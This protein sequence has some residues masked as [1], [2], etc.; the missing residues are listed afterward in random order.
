MRALK[1]DGRHARTIRTRAAIVTAVVD[2]LDEGRIEPTAAEI[3]DRAGVA[4]RSI[5]QHF[6]SREELLVAVAEHHASRIEARPIDASLPLGARLARF[7]VARAKL[8]EATRTMRGAAA[9]VAWRSPA[10]R[11][12]LQAAERMRRAETARLFA[13][14]IAS[15]DDPTATEQALALASSGRAWDAM[16][17]DLA[18]TSAN[19]RALLARLVTSAVRG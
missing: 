8:L 13:R 6:A 4:L 14:E 7:S 2:L 5:G 19:A 17:V 9:V 18:L 15:S 10:V 12:A 16:R 3:A 11:R 1:I